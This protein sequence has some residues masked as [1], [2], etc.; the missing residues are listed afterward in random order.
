MSAYPPDQRCPR[1]QYPVTP[2]AATC[3]N[4]GLALTGAA[5]AYPGSQPAYPSSST[6]PAAGSGSYSTLPASGPYG[7]GTPPGGAGSYG[8]SQPPTAYSSETMNS[9]PTVA[10]S[11][12]PQDP[13][14]YPGSQPQ[15]PLPPPPP[16]AYPGSPPQAS[17]GSSPYAGSQQPTVFAG[18]AAYPGGQPPGSF[19]A[20][21]TFPGGQFQGSFPGSVAA[22]PMTEPPAP[23]KG[24]GLKIAIIILVA[25]VI[26]GG[27]GGTAAY[28][29]TR[30]KP[31]I[32]VTS[33]YKVGTTYAGATDTVFHV[34]GSKFS[35]NSAITFLLDGN[36][37]PGAATPQS[38]SDGS[39][40]ADL[41]VTSNW[42]TGNHSLTARD[43]GGYVTQAGVSITIVAQG[44]AG[45][46]GPNGAPA[47]NKSFS[48]KA[49]VNPS[50]VN[51]GALRPFSDTLIITG[52]ADPNGGSV[53]QARDDGSQQTIDDTVSTSSGTLEYIETAVF[54]CTGAYKSGK[55]TYTETTVSA[56]FVFSNSL[57]CTANT[58][59]TEQQIDGTFGSATSISGSFSSDSISFSDCT[60]QFDAETGTWTGTL[61]S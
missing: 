16:P 27:G 54:K 5:G 59:F 51:G 44:E 22:P 52:K 19:G 3:A 28:L 33:D 4:C 14:G 23:K 30:P 40:T 18:P 2:G 46:P 39:I 36:P 58:P 47:D 48:I 12:Y 49:T 60:G 32:T 17:F 56:D 42:S 53:C 11:L 55:L 45:T 20:P 57:A 41:K 61:G 29:L 8:G 25:L 21:S 6:P 31:V 13:G 35:S 15:S 10:S 37:A 9:A 50:S 1:C 34:T 24:N 43:A 7:G 38:G 26:L